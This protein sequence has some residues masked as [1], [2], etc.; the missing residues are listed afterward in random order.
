MTK[1]LAVMAGV[2][3]LAAALAVTVRAQGGPSPISLADLLG[4][5][6]GKSSNF[7][8]DP[9]TQESLDK[10]KLDEDK[11]KF[12]KS[13]GKKLEDATKSWDSK[14]KIK[15]AAQTAYKGYKGY[16][17]LMQQYEQLTPADGPYDP[18]YQPPG[19]PEIPSSCAA[20]KT[21]GPCFADAQ[22]KL[23]AVRI[24]FEKLRVLY[25]S[26]KAWID[27]AIAFGDNMASAVG[28]GGLAWQ[29]ERTKIAASVA[30]LDQSYDN[31]Y[32]ELLAALEEA[33]RAIAACEAQ[34]FNNPDW[35]DRFGFM[36]YSFMADRYQ[37]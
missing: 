25:G 20:S 26:T 17:E 29:T 11:K 19:T 22:A 36:F 31:K 3:A 18:V 24:R 9:K 35:Y 33:L 27:R 30:N 21:C 15:S 34:Q 10:W 13:L 5:G 1:R 6:W 16:Q 28:I 7:G 12:E 37:R 8:P 32:K 2:A 14:A 23:T 4:G